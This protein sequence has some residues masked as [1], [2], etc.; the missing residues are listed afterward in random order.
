M[1]DQQPAGAGM[2]WRQRAACIGHDPELWFPKPRDT[3][4]A[5]RAEA[6]CARCPVINACRRAAK[7]E[8]HG[9]WAGRH[10]FASW[11][12]TP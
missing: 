3:T 12:T 1:P 5:E 7:R 4:T 11:E 6:I 8:Q 10:R 9:I 2:D